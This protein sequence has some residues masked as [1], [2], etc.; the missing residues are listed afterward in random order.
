[1]K[2]IGEIELGN[3]M[4]IFYN[5]IESYIVYGQLSINS[6]SLMEEEG[7]RGCAHLLEHCLFRGSEKYPTRKHIER[8]FANLGVKPNANTG[9]RQTNFPVKNIQRNFL[10][11]LEAV[12]DIAFSPLL[13]RI[14][15]EEEK[16][17]VLH[18]LGQYE[19]H[20]E[21]INERLFNK[22]FFRG[23]KA[24]KMIIGNR[25]DIIRV[26]HCDVLKFHEEN[27]TPANADFYVGGDIDKA[28]LEGICSILGRF[29]DGE[30]I[31]SVSIKLQELNENEIVKESIKGLQR[32]YGKIIFRTPISSNEEEVFMPMLSYVLNGSGRS[33]LF[34]K[35]RQRK[36]MAYEIYTKSIS[37]KD[38][39]YLYVS[40]SVEPKKADEV[41]QTCIEHFKVFNPA[42]R[43]VEMART[44]LELQYAKE[45]DERG[46]A[47]SDFLALEK[48]G[49]DR[50]EYRRRALETTQK[51][52]IE[53]AQKY[54][55]GTHQIALLVPK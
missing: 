5:R 42:Q 29:S 8:A 32:T 55:S 18:E 17:I 49:I 53:F 3:G 13:S 36:G 43:E 20:L 19:D 48:N 38:F 30:K 45:L 21:F 12:A 6:G 54:L 33:S 14:G 52:L 51:D 40:F 37:D 27:Y 15:L 22:V 4:R 11:A 24:E 9:F 10:P 23:T 25:G 26:K 7:K 31:D 34:E 16:N 2:K 46:S 50:N 47:F 44:A 28:C 1:M 35:I 39:G 41:I